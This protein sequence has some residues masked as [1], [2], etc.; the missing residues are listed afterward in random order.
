[1]YIDFSSL[2]SLSQLKALWAILSY[3]SSYSVLAESDV[4]YHLL[5]SRELIYWYTLPALYCSSDA[6]Q[7]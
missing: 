6:K 5:Y 4:C 1:M 7:H 2:P 3:V